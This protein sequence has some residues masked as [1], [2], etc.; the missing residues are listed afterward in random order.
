MLSWKL[1]EYIASN[2]NGVST[3][4]CVVQSLRINISFFLLT[5]C[6]DELIWTPKV[7]TF[8]PQSKFGSEKSKRESNPI[9]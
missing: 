8:L 1:I 3:N 6:N 2:I 9:P 4:P 5:T 7:I